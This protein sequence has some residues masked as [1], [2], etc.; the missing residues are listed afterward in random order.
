MKA[1]IVS[2][3]LWHQSAGDQDL[4]LCSLPL[5]LLC[6]FG[7]VQNIL[8]VQG[9]AGIMSI[10]IMNKLHLRIPKQ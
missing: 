6:L 10:V 9:F 3:L 2:K 7:Q 8:R 5:G 4:V 1:L